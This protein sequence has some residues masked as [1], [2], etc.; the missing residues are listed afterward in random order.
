ML[1]TDRSLMSPKKPSLQQRSNPVAA[2]QKVVSDIGVF[3]H[4]LSHIP[5]SPQVV[6]PSPSVGSHHAARFHGFLD[7]WTEAYSRSIPYSPKTNPADAFVVHLRGD[8]HQCLTHSSA[9]PFSGLFSSN[10]G[11]IHFNR[12]SKSV[13]S[14]P[15]HCT[16]KLMQPCPGRFVAAK[17]KNSLKPLR[18]RTVLLAGDP[19]DRA[20]P[21]RQRKA[22]PF[23]NR[24][25]FSRDLIATPGTF[26][27]TTARQPALRGLTSRADESLRPPQTIQVFHAGRLRGESPIE[28]GQSF[29]III[30]N[31]AYYILGMVDSRGYPKSKIK[32]VEL[33]S[34]NRAE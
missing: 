7:S 13:P 4:D 29:R 3:T 14:R 34:K 33:R 30:H 27:Q 5:Q 22:R 11:L 12:T 32:K 25:G 26:A 16:S 10:V 28:F 19:P 21:H 17:S 31:L 24:P 15:D 18:T 9:A 23:K 6:L 8:H 1:M 20:E 2:R